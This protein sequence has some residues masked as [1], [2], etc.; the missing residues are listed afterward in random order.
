MNTKLLMICIVALIVPLA[1]AQFDFGLGQTGTSTPWTEFNLNPKTKVKL[2][3]RN[4]NTDMVLAFFQRTTGITI[5]KDPGFS[6]PITVTSASE[7]S[8][9]EAFQILNTVMTLKNFELKKEG[10]L[11]VMRAKPQRNAGG[12]GQFDP[13]SM[14]PPGMDMTQFQQAPIVL[15]VYPIKFANA[16]QVARVLNEV[17]IQQQSTDP[18][19]QIIQQMQQ[20]GGM[21]RGGFGGMQR[22][23]FGGRGGATGTSNVRAS[24]DDYSNTVIVNAPEKEQVQV[25]SL[26]KE[27]DR[28]TDQPLQ[29]RVFKLEFASSDIVAPIVNNVLIA[30]APKGRGGQGSQQVP[31]EQRFQQAFRFGNAQSAFGNVVSDPRT[32]S[33]IVTATEENLVLVEKVVKELDTEVVYENSTFVFPL[34]NARADSIA[35]LLQQAFGT[36]GTTTGNRNTGQTG[37]RTTTNNRNNQNN[38]NQG[39]GGGGGGGGAR[40]GGGDP[41]TNTVG[42]DLE[43]PNATSGDL[44]TSIDVQQGFGGFGGQNR[45]GQQGRTGTATQQAQGRDD[46]GRLI[47]TRDLAGQVTV[48]PDPNT[49]SLIVVTGPENV[50]LIKQILAQ[51]DRIPEQVMIETLIV[52]ATLD[53]SSKLG[54]E[55]SFMQNKAFGDAGVTG[56]A[57]S[58]FGLGGTNAAALQ[59]VKYTLTG[60]NL[61]TLM[62]ALKTDQKF[63]VLSTPRIFTSNNVQAS[64]NIS[65][66]VPYVLSQREDANGNLTFNYAFQDVGIVLTVTPR[67]TSN[68]YVT[69][70]VSQTANELQGFTTFNAPIVNT[71]EATTT[72]SVKDSETIILGGIIRSSVSSTTNKIPLLGDIPILGKLFQS[73]KKEDVK[74]E[75]LVFL[76][77]R[78]VRDEDEARRLREESVNKAEPSTKDVIQKHIPPPVKGGG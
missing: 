47:N 36:R 61:T 2:D 46:Q 4:A 73:S 20:R 53:Q 17:F 43:D 35:T 11:L 16:A 41:E 54:V 71:R 68:G 60:G 1:G 64:I 5:V 3:F 6:G 78:I 27:I 26:I 42:I 69:M 57:S 22:G 44:L 23:G 12:R 45:G 38:R 24:S 10:N 52:E 14:F 13:T 70:D 21:N 77:P 33:L 72:V 51:L 9:N 58:N 7:V 40:G 50:D 31:I 49:N 55:W 56:T 48:I 32:N 8:L 34:S 37:Q 66:R 67:I 39:G 30:N 65:Q 19:T 62:N 76:T 29:P 28:Q 63:R 25:A 75:L 74:T 18:M 59:G 15:H